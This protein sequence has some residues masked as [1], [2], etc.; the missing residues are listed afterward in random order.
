MS[1]SKRT[2]YEMK[3]IAITTSPE[4]YGLM[5]NVIDCSVRLSHCKFIIKEKYPELLP[6]VTDDIIEK[7]ARL[8]H[9]IKKLNSISVIQK[10]YHNK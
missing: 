1:I 7:N 2:M 8:Y 5:F 4:F 6:F 9:L 3:K 10:L